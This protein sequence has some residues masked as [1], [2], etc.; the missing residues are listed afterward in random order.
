MQVSEDIC[1]SGVI[2][3]AKL[4]EFLHTEDSGRHCEVPEA[5]RVE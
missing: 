4:P 3:C 2:I 5:G 1:H